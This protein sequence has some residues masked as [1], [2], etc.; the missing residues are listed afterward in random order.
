MD[1]QTVE[2][3]VKSPP[4]GITSQVATAPEESEAGLRPGEGKK[5][6]LLANLLFGLY[7]LPVA[8][9]RRLIRGALIALE[10]DEFRS[11]TLRR[12]FAVYHQVEVGMYSH[13]GC[14]ILDALPPGTR[15]GRFCSI[16]RQARAFNANHPMN[17]RSTHAIFFNPLLGYAKSDI[18]PRSRLTIGHDVWIGCGAI[19][20]PSV[21]SIGDGAVIG[22]GAVVNKNIPPYAI[23][24]GNPGQ[25][26][27]YRFSKETIQQ[28]QAS[29]WWEKSIEELL[30]ELEQ[31][32]VPLEG[33][34]V[35]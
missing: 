11:L 26:V 34:Q 18:I 14:F 35:R 9:V 29:R 5:A 22:A 13:G 10:G 2:G 21:T 19:L 32:Q 17:L 23:V 33:D 8:W 7:A 1:T 15:V 28:V 6:G 16:H 4:E 30:P 31:F 25:V 12:I 27:R 20:L 3:K 24:V